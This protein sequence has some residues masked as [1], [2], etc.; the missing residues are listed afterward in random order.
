M[1]HDVHMK[2][3][4]R[5]FLPY[6]GL[7][8]IIFI[9]LLFGAVLLQYWDFGMKYC[10]SGKVELCDIGNLLDDSCDIAVDEDGYITTGN[11]PGFAAYITG[12][13]VVDIVLS[14]LPKEGSLGELY[15]A[16]KT[17]YYSQQS[18]ELRVYHNGHNLAVLP[19]DQCDRIHVDV[20][21]TDGVHFQVK[22]IMSGSPW[23][24]YLFTYWKQLALLALALVVL[25]WCI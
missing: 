13:P 12:G 15:Y 25:L 17:A 20:A 21:L 3:I 5:R 9:F 19:A 7:Y 2:K 8:I 16:E 11:N 6:C 23:K 24:L 1:K 22:S 18:S 14:G 10:L 4:M